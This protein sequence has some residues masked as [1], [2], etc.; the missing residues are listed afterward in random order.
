[1]TI[2]KCGVCPGASYRWSVRTVLLCRQ[3]LWRHGI[4]NKSEKRDD[5]RKI[6]LGIAVILFGILMEVST[7]GHLAYFAWIIG[8]AGLGLAAFGCF[9]KEEK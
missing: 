7:D 6:G 1:M 4:M 8:L 3:V 5:M 9:G 2:P